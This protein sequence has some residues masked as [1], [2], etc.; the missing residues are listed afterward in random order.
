MSVSNLAEGDWLAI[1]LRGNKKLANAFSG[2]NYV[3]TVWDRSYLLR[4][5]SEQD[6][7]IP[8]QAAVSSPL[9]IQTPPETAGFF[10]AAKTSRSVTVRS[11]TVVALD[12]GHGRG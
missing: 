8:A 3:E 6:E 1:G 9:Q 10:H 7:R 4:E 2:K 5:P 12:T 11:V